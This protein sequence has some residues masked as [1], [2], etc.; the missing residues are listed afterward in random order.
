[1]LRCMVEPPAPTSRPVQRRTWPDILAYAVLVLGGVLLLAAGVLFMAAST[2]DEWAW[3]G[4]YYAAGIAVFE[5]PAIAL[6]LIALS[7][8][9]NT[10]R[11]ARLVASLAALLV[12]CPLL[13]WGLWGL[14]F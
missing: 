2:G 4:Y 3:V 12:V 1:M 6:A 5:V 7:A 9:R 10:P 13:L 8:R 11:R 14:S